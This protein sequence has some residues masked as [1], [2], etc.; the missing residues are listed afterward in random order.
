MILN[1]RF[2]EPE[3]TIFPQH[4]N[5][6]KGCLS[7]LGRTGPKRRKAGLENCSKPACFCLYQR[8]PILLTATTMVS[9]P[10]TIR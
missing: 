7:R 1:V 5:K 3:K 6:L 8:D 10:I 9:I 2:A 4:N